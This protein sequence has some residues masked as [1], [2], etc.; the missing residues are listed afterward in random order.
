MYIIYI[1]VDDNVRFFVV[2]VNLYEL[3]CYNKLL[4]L[5]FHIPHIFLYPTLPTPLSH[6]QTKMY[7]QTFLFENLKRFETLK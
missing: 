2:T 5:L 3:S 4:S 7:R 1:S 6:F